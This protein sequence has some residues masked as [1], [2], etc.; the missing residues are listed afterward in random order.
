[1]EA[2]VEALVD[3]T[4]VEITSVEAS[5]TSLKTSVFC[6]GSFRTSMKSSMKAS[7]EAIEAFMEAVAASMEGFVS[8]HARNKWCR[9]DRTNAFEVSSI[10]RDMELDPH[11]RSVENS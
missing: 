11:V 7:M 6:H 8:F 4:S 10:A 5:T 3:V 9:R 2:L 1:M